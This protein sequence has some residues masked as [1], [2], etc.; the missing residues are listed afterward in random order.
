M[1]TCVLYAV[2]QLV[3]GPQFTLFPDSYRYARA[4]EGYLGASPA[5][6]HRKAL[7]AYCASRADRAAHDRRLEP[8]ARQSER[9]IS[10]GE[11]RACLERWADAPDITTDDPRYQAIFAG[12]PGYPLLAA[13]FVAGFGVLSGMR[14]LGVLT[15]AAGSLLVLG[16]LRS[17]GLTRRAALAGQVTFLATP[18][19][20][21]SAQ[22]LSEGLFTLGTLGVLWGGLLL[23]RRRSV[24]AAV[25]LTAVSYGVAAFT[26]YSSALVFAALLAAITAGA[27]CLPGRAR[28]RG[29]AAF[30]GLSVAAAGG[31]AVAMRALGLPST[32]D[33]LQDTFTHHFE[34]PDVS[35][36]WRELLGLAWRFWRDWS[37]QQAALPYFLLLTALAAWALVRYGDGLGRLALAAALT[38]ALQ[39][40]AH[41]LVL[42]AGRLG[43]LMWTPVVLGLPLVVDR[44][45]AARP[46]REPAERGGAAPDPL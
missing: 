6:A 7:A 25:A 20:W 4:A 9:T 22:A 30:A 3:A 27:L 40:T 33:T 35:D 5:E 10:A 11:E 28:H 32:Q 42:E 34:A 29:T 39:V 31:V 46:S 43:A 13:P 23:C 38:G 2:L 36:P 41:P 37:A 17:A 16:L 1:L 44:H 14:L 24:P 8:T 19:G 12:R 45:W 18:L 15:A 21:W 26:R